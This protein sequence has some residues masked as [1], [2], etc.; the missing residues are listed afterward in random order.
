MRNLKLVLGTM[1]LGAFLA[2]PAFAA[3][4]AKKEEPAHKVVGAAK[5][6]MCHNSAAK[7]AQFKV[8]SE[9]KHA[10]AFATLATDEAKKIA[11]EKGIADPQKDAK[12]L[13]CHETGYGKPAALFEATFKPEDGVQCEACHGAGKDY[14]AMA[15]MKDLRAKKKEPA[16]VGLVLPT[17]KECVACHNSE[18][19]TFKSFDFKEAVAKIAHNYPKS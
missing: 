18:S 9:S 2:G 17:E 8:W 10:K 19:P 6:K 5:C 7:G 11:K 1:V 3:D 14:M 16:S 15:V 12:C 13:K 4:A